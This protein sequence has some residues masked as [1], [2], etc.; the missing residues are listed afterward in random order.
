[1]PRPRKD[2]KEKG[3]EE[4]MVEAFWR[5]L[6]HMPYRELTA[7]SIARE[8]ECNRA[9]FYYYFESIEDLAEQA[10]DA[11]VPTSIADLA[12]K[13][14]SEDGAS[15]RLDE[16]QRRA[17]E[18]ISLLTGANGSARLTERFKQALMEAWAN[19]FSLDL[20]QEDVRT[21]ASFMA[22]GIIGILGERAG[23]PCDG[24]FD[25]RLQIISEVFSAPAIEFA[26][27]IGGVES[28]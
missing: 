19:R 25:A 1:M 11:A 22:S 26:H 14:L 21:V 8:A 10:V 24:H 2:S 15:F 3:A 12:E 13:F 5:Q 18:R 23:R 20:E 6:A 4:R 9:T 27:R 28:S 17:V 16:K 7:V